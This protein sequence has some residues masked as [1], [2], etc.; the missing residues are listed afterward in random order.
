M[1]ILV[2]AFVEMSR[3]KIQDGGSCHFGEKSKYNQ[4]LINIP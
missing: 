4:M 1:A 3:F 2:L